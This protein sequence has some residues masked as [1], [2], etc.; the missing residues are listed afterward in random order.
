MHLIRSISACL[1]LSFA[2]L[3]AWDART[4]LTLSTTVQYAL[5]NLVSGTAVTTKRGKTQITVTPI[6]TWKSVSDHWCR[7]Y[8]VIVTAPGKA[9]NRTEETR[10]RQTGIWKRLPRE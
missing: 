8:A 1:A 5:E 4:E 7:L 3:P 9:Q 10:C 6:R 2:S